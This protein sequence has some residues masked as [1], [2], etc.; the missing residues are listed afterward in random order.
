MSH[1]PKTRARVLLLFPVLL[2]A[3]QETRDLVCPFASLAKLGALVLELG[4]NG[5]LCPSRALLE[6]SG[7]VVY[8]GV[9]PTS[10]FLA[11]CREHFL[12]HITHSFKCY[13]KSHMP[14]AP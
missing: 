8:S 12:S 9:L 11:S 10:P 7:A 5:H 6:G 13:M 4:T 3:K 14:D 1:K 2:L